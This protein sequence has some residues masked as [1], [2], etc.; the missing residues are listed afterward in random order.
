MVKY[1]SPVANNGSEIREALRFAEP[2]TAS[3]ARMPGAPTEQSRHSLGQSCARLVLAR[4]DAELALESAGEI[5][6]IVESDGTSHVL[7]ERAGLST[8]KHGSPRA[9]APAGGRGLLARQE[10]CT[11]LL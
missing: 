6:K 10:L 4:A 3:Q 9:F 1:S 2:R 8:M 5:R 11:T 7:D